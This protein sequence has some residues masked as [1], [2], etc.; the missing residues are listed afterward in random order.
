MDQAIE[1]CLGDTMNEIDTELF[2]AIKSEDHNAVYRALDEGANPNARNVDGCTAVMKAIEDTHSAIIVQLLVD[3]GGDVNAKDSK[4]QTALM[5]AGQ[6]TKM[7]KA[8]IDLGA[9][10]NAKDKAGYTALKYVWGNN[11]LLLLE[12]GISANDASGA[13]VLKNAISN[14]N[15]YHVEKLVQ[16]GARVDTLDVDQLDYL[17]SL[18]TEHAQMLLESGLF[19]E[20][21]ESDISRRGAYSKS[22]IG[23]AIACGNVKIV[24]RLIEN[25]A[26]LNLSDQEGVTSL[27]YAAAF[28]LEDIYSLLLKAGADSTTNDIHGLTIVDWAIRGGN[29][30]IVRMIGNASGM[31]ISEENNGRHEAIT[32]EEFQIYSRILKEHYI[33]SGAKRLVINENTD[34]VR[35]HED[36]IFGT[37]YLHHLWYHAPEAPLS[38]LWDFVSRNKESYRFEH[39]SG[40]GIDCELIDKEIMRSIFAGENAQEGIDKE[41]TYCKSDYGWQKFHRAYPESGGIIS[42]S[43]I[44]FNAEM[45]IAIAIAGMYAG[46][47]AGDGYIFLMQKRN[48]TWDIKE[49][50]LMWDA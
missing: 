27:M 43:R 8:L 41:D 35:F 46:S 39:E 25:G 4:G 1:A 36:S 23:K 38:L 17:M 40:F 50:I 15:A 34:P 14:H 19:L 20:T 10:L 30:A 9:D 24:E 3:R 5:K 31:V 2:K 49:E 16:A 28:G 32:E 11:T 26:D 45:N 33:Q 42:F 21:D 48:G 12:S 44:G 18:N 37:N 13:E 22:A 29:Q 47:E 7:A 6:K